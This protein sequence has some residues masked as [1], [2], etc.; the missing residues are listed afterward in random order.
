MYVMCYLFIIPGWF[1]LD[2]FFEYEL[3]GALQPLVF[4][5]FNF[6]FYNFEI[7]IILIPARRAP[8]IFLTQGKIPEICQTFCKIC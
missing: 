4:F 3:I 5:N 6:F 8:G 7:I 1:L 2:V